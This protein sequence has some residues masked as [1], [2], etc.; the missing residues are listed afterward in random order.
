MSIIFHKEI[1]IFP[2][3]NSKI[4]DFFQPVQEGGR[5][6]FTGLSSSS[7]YPLRRGLW[8]ACYRIH[9]LLCIPNCFTVK[10]AQSTP[11][12]RTMISCTAANLQQNG[13]KKSKESMFWLVPEKVQSSTWIESCG[14]TLIAVTPQRRMCFWNYGLKSQFKRESSFYKC[15]LLP[16]LSG[17]SPGSASTS[18]KSNQEKEDDESDVSS[19]KSRPL[20]PSNTGETS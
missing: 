20:T 2:H 1:F 3:I 9:E 6:H 5:S 13:E 8:F 11:C 18:P 17:L 10:C 15:P 7:G 14:R 4:L 16:S 19:H 12:N